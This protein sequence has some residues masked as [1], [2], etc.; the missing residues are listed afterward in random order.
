MKKILLFLWQSPQNI[1]G[2]LVILFTNAKPRLF[3]AESIKFWFSPVA[4]FGISLGN[5]IILGG[6][7]ESK[8]IKHEF[9][10]QK[11]SLYLGWLYLLVIGI[12][13]FLG[14]I[15]DRVAHRNWLVSERIKWY[16]NQPWEKWADELGNVNRFN[17]G[18]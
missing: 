17:S 7:Y 10:H 2:I 4:R 11:Q 16:Y 8:N 1:L 6:Y 3:Q 13:S 12:P 9:G 15:W 18:V 5:F 14:N